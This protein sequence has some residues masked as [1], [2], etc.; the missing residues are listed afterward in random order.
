M[1]TGHGILNGMVER[2]FRRLRTVIRVGTFRGRRRI[3]LGD[4]VV[5]RLQ[6][7]IRE[8][9]NHFLKDCGQWVLNAQMIL[10]GLLFATIRKRNG[11]KRFQFI[12]VMHFENGCFS[13]R[14]VI[15][16][17]AF[18]QVLLLFGGRLFVGRSTVVAAGGR[19][20]RIFRHIVYR[21]NFRAFTTM[22]IL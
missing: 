12:I 14:F 8:L 7:C 13:S 4:K 17:L 18:F 21:Q 5:D 2:N 15:D 22:M 10:C 16:H 9:L 1:E 11:K 19:L 20:V 3:H 6:L